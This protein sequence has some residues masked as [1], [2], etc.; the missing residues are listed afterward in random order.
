MKILLCM[1]PTAI[2]LGKQW[3]TFHLGLGY[4]AG[5]LKSEGHE[6]AIFDPNVLPKEFFT[7]SQRHGDQ[8]SEIGLNDEDYSHYVWPG[9]VYALRKFS[10]DVIGVSFKVIEIKLALMICRLS[11]RIFP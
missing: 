9:Y 11:K 7:A 10:P 4:L 8:I 1:P 3:H 6:V 2:L 5:A